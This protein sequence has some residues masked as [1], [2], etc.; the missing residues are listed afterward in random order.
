MIATQQ[1]YVEIRKNRDGE[2]RAYLTGTRI[3]VLD[4]V[5]YRERFGHSVEDL[6]KS[7]PQLSIAQVHGALAYYHEDPQ[8]IWRSIEEDEAFAKAME[9]EL[10]KTRQEQNV[11]DSS[12][13][14]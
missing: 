4:L 5:I 2:D 11:R 9:Q 8:A 12:I 6:A 13:S 7:F 3:R 1:Q 10:T 14:P